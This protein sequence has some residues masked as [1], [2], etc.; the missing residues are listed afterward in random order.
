MVH[1]LCPGAKRPE[2]RDYIV[3]DLLRRSNDRGIQRVGSPI[4]LDDFFTFGNQAL[5]R[6]A[7]LALELLPRRLGSLFQPGNVTFGFLEMRLDGLRNSCDCA[8]LII[9]GKAVVN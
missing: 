9:F 3:I 5:H 7:R 4:F 1:L 2:T 6:L 8:A